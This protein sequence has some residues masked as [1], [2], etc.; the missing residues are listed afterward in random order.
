MK[1]EELILHSMSELQLLHAKKQIAKEMRRR[2]QP[3]EAT[4]PAR[5]K[6]SQSGTHARVTV[7][8]KKTA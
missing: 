7:P 1:R 8:K 4:V 5:K 2:S 6:S 3:P